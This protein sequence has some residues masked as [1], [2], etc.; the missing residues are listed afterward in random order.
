MERR[1][2][3]CETCKW[4]ESDSEVIERDND[5]RNGRWVSGPFYP[6]CH[7]APKTRKKYKNDW[8]SKWQS[9]ESI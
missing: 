5:R 7:L 3:R 2:E 8:C 4:H 6:L 1:K 9:K